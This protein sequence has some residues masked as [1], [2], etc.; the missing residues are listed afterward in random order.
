MGDATF[1][2]TDK[3]PGGMF[4]GFCY[5]LRKYELDVSLT[6]WMTLLEALDKG[7][8]K[9]SLNEF[10]YI[11]R[12]ILAKTE[13]EYDKFDLAFLDYFKNMGPGAEP[14][15]DVAKWINAGEAADAPARLSR[16]TAPADSNNDNIA[17]FTGNAFANNSSAMGEGAGGLEGNANM[18]GSETAKSAFDVAGSRTF[19]DF[20]NDTLI[21]ERQ[22]QVVFRRLRQLSN[23]ANVPESELDVDSTIRKTCDKGGILHVAMKKPR[24]NIIKLMLLMDSGGSMQA[25]SKF[26]TA[27]FQAAMKSNTFQDLK[28]YYFH[29]CIYNKLYKD[30]A[31]TKETEVSTEWVL[32]NIA[33]DYKVIIVGD[34][35]MSPAE[36]STANY[37]REPGEQSLSGMQWMQLFKKKYRKIVWLN[38]EDE[39]FSWRDTFTRQWL[40]TE[41]DM[42]LFTLKNFEIAI[43]KLL[44]G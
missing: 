34:A 5:T 27:L 23:N 16:N 31:C 10:Y 25:Y 41:F 4:T 40:A 1:L 15:P 32:K 9:C 29:N 26:C 43:K 14:P 37:Y 24:R 30:P 28:I 2:Q 7:L 17:V 39:D 35:A 38:P 6:E 22:F 8:A 21:D 12:A 18:V 33:N 36:L 13:R 19:R 3:Q 20:R 42:Y 44:A 11:S